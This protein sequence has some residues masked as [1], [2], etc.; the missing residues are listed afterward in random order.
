MADAIHDRL[1]KGEDFA[2]VAGEVSDS[3]SKATG[4]LIGDVNV[5]DMSDTLRP[6]IDA[7]KP[8]E[9]TPPIRTQRGYQLLKLDSR[10]PEQPKPFEDVREAI[11]QKI[12]EQRVD[13]E[14][15]KYLDKVRGQALIEWK[16]QNL[17][18]MYDK[19]L[20]DMKKAGGV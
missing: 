18:D 13:G 6:L 8:G 4:G 5:N 20:N 11:A 15:E 19:Q 9:V 1:T 2:K 10:S 7:L 16:D 12:Y 17:E 3:P 14:T